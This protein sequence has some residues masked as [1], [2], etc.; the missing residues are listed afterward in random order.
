VESSTEPQTNTPTASK[1][2]NYTESQ[3]NAPNLAPLLLSTKPI[4]AVTQM[5]GVA[6]L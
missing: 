5:R 2:E 6:E 1:E 3:T 4:E